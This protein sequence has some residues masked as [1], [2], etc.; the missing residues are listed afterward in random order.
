MRGEGYGY[1]FFQNISDVIFERSL[2]NW[3][4]SDFADFLLMLRSRGTLGKDGDQGRFSRQS[5][6]AFHGG[7]PKQ[8]VRLWRRSRLL[9]RP[10]NTP[11]DVR[12]YGKKPI[13]LNCTAVLC[14]ASSVF[15]SNQV[16]TY[17]QFL[18]KYITTK[19]ICQ[20]IGICRVKAG[21][22]SFQNM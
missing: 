4:W 7:I 15:T 19:K 18:W 11:L 6:R 13:A 1:F 5:S 8:P 22:F 17:T 16:H 20:K 21:I 12:H 3:F 10:W 14:R 2:I 9:Q